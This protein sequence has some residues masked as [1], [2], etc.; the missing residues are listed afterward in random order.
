MLEGAAAA[1]GTAPVDRVI[2]ALDCP[3]DE[4]YALADRLAGTATFL[5]VGMTLYYSAGPQVVRRLRE[6]GFK[7]FVDLKLHDIPH[8]VEGAARSLAQVGAELMTVHASGGAEMMRAALDGASA[9]DAGRRAGVD[10]PAV[11]GV[12]VL[13]SMSDQDLA[14]VG[15]SRTAAE[16]VRSLAGLVGEAGLDGVV[17]SPREASLMRRALGPGAL[18]VTPGVRPAGSASDDQQRVATPA[19]A[20]GDGASHLVVGRPITRSADPLSVFNAIVEEVA[21]A[22]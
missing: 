14:S 3:E 22:L 5:K 1:L 12:T 21:S 6:Q 2:V 20:I 16:Q 4:A 7:V 11:I 8:Q 13:T 15:V 9:G 17:C 18:V 10:R 19:K